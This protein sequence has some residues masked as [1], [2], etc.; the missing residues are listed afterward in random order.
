LRFTQLPIDSGIDESRLSLIEN[1][2]RNIQFP[3][4]SGIDVIL[5]AFREI[6]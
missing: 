1:L 4:E 2:V 5:F 3:I 6:S